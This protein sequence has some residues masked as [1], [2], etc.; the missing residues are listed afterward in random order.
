MTNDNG[1][2]AM[3]VERQQRC[4]TNGKQQSTNAQHAQGQTS[5]NGRMRWRTTGRRRLKRRRWIWSNGQANMVG[6]RRATTVLP[7]MT[8]KQQS[9]NERRQR[10]RTTMADERRGAVVE[11]EEQLLCGGRGFMLRSWRMEVE[12]GWGC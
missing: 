10:R 12:D 8:K 11:A 4:P 1:K 7:K 5:G 3:V 6:G 2:A 9:T